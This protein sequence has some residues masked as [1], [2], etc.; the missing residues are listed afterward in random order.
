MFPQADAAGSSPS[1]SVSNR[2][3]PRV[4]SVMTRPQ[5][6]VD[7]ELRGGTDVTRKGRSLPRA[8]QIANLTTNDAA[9]PAQP[10]MAGGVGLVLCKRHLFGIG[11]E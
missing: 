7:A 9:R 11:G 3:V 6:S 10:R 5:P 4:Q 8:G 1:A 2:E